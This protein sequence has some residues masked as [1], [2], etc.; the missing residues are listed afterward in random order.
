MTTEDMIISIVI[1][2]DD[3]LPK[4]EKDSQ[5]KLYPSELVTIGI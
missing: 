2:V 5:S 3:K 4:I 1:I